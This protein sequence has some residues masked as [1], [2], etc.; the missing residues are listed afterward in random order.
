MTTRARLAVRWLGFFSLTI[1]PSVLVLGLFFLNRMINPYVLGIS[2]AGAVFGLFMAVKTVESMRGLADDDKTAWW[3][4]TA[5]TRD[6]AQAQSGERDAGQEKLLDELRGRKDARL[7]ASSAKPAH[8]RSLDDAALQSQVARLLKKMGRRV[9][10]T[11][12]AEYRGFDLV[13][14]NNTIVKCSAQ[15]KRMANPAAEKLL[16]TFRGQPACTTAILVWPK[17]FP[18]RTRYLTRSSDV[19]LWDAEN[20]ARLVASRRLA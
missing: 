16:A 14:D 1:L 3:L 20:I 12:D 7:P 6:R 8:W 10:R 4:K 17:G 13:V 19:I 9:Q 5:E 11:G 15:P 18:A 2:L